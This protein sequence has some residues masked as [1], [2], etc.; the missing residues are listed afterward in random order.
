VQY[1][2][3]NYNYSDRFNTNRYG[4]QR[5]QPPPQLPQRASQPYIQTPSS[6]SFPILPPYIN[7]I[8]GDEKSYSTRDQNQYHTLPPIIKLPKQNIDFISCNIPYKEK[9]FIEGLRIVVGPVS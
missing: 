1:R 8:V 4:Q 3:N 7:Q 6:S 5:H 2:V 9:K